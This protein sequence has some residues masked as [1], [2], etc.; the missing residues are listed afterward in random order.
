MRKLNNGEG[1]DVENVEPF[2]EPKPE[3]I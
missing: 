1:Y 3:V 2:K